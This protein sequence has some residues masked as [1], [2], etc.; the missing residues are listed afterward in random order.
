MEDL[1]LGSNKN[2]SGQK[3]NQGPL[4]PDRNTLACGL[5]GFTWPDE[6]W[7]YHILTGMKWSN[8]LF[9]HEHAKYSHLQP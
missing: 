4:S 5:P 8:Q 6:R 3:H 7:I 2:N 9:L 1:R